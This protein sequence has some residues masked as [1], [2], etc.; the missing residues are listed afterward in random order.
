MIAVRIVFAVIA[1]ALALRLWWSFTRTR[2][3]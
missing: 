3:K 2:R 1:G